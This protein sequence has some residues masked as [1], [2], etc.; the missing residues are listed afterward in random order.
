MIPL[1]DENPTTRPPIV[2]VSLI[3]ACV[4]VFLWQFGLSEPTEARRIYA[5]GTIPALLLGDRSLPPEIYLIPPEVT[6]VTSLFLHGGWMHLIGNML[7]LWV[8]GNNIEDEFG[9]FKFLAFY[10]LCGI[11][12][13]LAHAAQ[14]PSSTVPLVGASGA[15]SGILGA[16]VVLY[17]NARVLTLVPF[18]IF[19]LI[20]LRAVVLIGI[21][22]AFQLL[23]A[24]MAAGGN[25]AYLAHIGGFIAGLALLYVFKPKK[26]ARATPRRGPWG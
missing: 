19:F 13:G 25:I 12:A 7:Y 16:Y 26:A 6:L 23:N 9:H 3:A 22:F 10:L 4:L 18:F 1:R 8:F 21:W 15:I 11:V 17:P 24:W 2:T 14:D 5:L 20:R